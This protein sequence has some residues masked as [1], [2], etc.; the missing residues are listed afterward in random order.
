M[1]SSSRYLCMYVSKGKRKEKEK[2]WIWWERKEGM[3]KDSNAGLQLPVRS[4]VNERAIAL[5]MDSIKCV[6]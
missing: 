1:G 4:E 5:A 3:W 2:R 6:G